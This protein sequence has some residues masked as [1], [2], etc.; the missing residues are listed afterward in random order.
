MPRA[1]SLRRLVNADRGCQSDQSISGRHLDDIGAR[2]KK[3]SGIVEYGGY[4]RNG[5]ATALGATMLGQVCRRPDLGSPCDFT[6]HLS[7]RLGMSSDSAKRQ[8][9]DWL[10]N[11]EPRVRRPIVELCSAQFLA[12]ADG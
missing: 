12:D 7:Q 2:A 11:Y 1:Q 3:T 10:S 8:L 5:M 6:E 9:A 4:E